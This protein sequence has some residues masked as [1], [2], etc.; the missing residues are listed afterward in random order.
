ML[1]AL[2]LA[3]ATLAGCVTNSEEPEMDVVTSIRL[4]VLS[5]CED[6]S[7]I[8]RV[9]NPDAEKSTI[10][11]DVAEQ[12]GAEQDEDGTLEVPIDGI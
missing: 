1:V 7:R 4:C 2:G 8:E 6:Q 3:T 11:E 10:T 5:L 9:G 12:M